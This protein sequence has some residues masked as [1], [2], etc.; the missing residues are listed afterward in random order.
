MCV[1]QN[2]KYVFINLFKVD[3]D[4]NSETAEAHDIS[5]MPT[6]K[7]FKDGKQVDEMVGASE[8]K[9]KAMIEKNK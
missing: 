9:L 8:D 4:I 5:A 6:F 1:L 3:V 7:C 2:I